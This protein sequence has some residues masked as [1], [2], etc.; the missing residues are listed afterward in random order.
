MESSHPRYIGISIPRPRWRRPSIDPQNRRQ[1]HSS[2]LSSSV[3]V[4]TS[5]LLITVVAVLV[6]AIATVADHINLIFH[7]QGVFSK[8]RRVPQ[9]ELALAINNPNSLKTEVLPPSMPSPLP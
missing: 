7:A 6:T 1:R 3:I 2:P 9:I 4:S 5:A 8:L